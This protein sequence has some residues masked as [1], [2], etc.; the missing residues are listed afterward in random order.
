MLRGG[1]TLKM[2]GWLRRDGDVGG[3]PRAPRFAP[4]MKRYHGSLPSFSPGFESRR[5]HCHSHQHSIQTHQCSSLLTGSSH[6]HTGP[7]DLTYFFRGGLP[8]SAS[9][10]FVASSF[11]FSLAGWT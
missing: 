4:V 7:P 5:V 8:A 1:N 10:L 6:S 9:F 3:H 2:A 11:A